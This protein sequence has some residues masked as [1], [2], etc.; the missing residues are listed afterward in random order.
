LRSNVQFCQPSYTFRRGHKSRNPRTAGSRHVH[1]VS[2][3]RTSLDAELLAK[4]DS[5]RGAGR[6]IETMAFPITTTW[7]R[8]QMQAS[9]RGLIRDRSP[10]P[11]GFLC[12]VASHCN[13]ID[14][15][16]SSQT[17]LTVRCYASKRY[18]L[19]YDSVSREK[20]TRH[21]NFS[22]ATHH[23]NIHLT[24]PK[25]LQPHAAGRNKPPVFLQAFFR[26]A[27]SCTAD[28]RTR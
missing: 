18:D 8:P 2:L 20:M 12:H 26:R 24:T 10:D 6:S 3:G 17:A 9:R 28:V 21:V 5:I 13:Q 4:R 15:K 22:A 23:I 19:P 7:R 14:R 1:V 25:Y 11:E 16:A 27:Q